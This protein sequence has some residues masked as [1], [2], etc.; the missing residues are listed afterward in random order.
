MPTITVLLDR[1]VDAN[2]VI[3]FE[4]VGRGFMS[5]EGQ[6][7]K[8]VVILLSEA[9]WKSAFAA[10]PDV[11]GKTISLNN[12]FYAIA[13][14]IPIDRQ[15][16]LDSRTQAW[17]PLVD[18]PGGDKYSNSTVIDV[19][20]RLRPGITMEQAQRETAAA[21]QRLGLSKGDTGWLHRLNAPLGGETWTALFSLMA[22]VCFL[23]LIACANIANLLLERTTTRQRETAIR[24]AIGA[25][26]FRLMKQFLV[27]SLVLSA[28]GTLAALILVWWGLRL[29]PK[30]LIPNL[31]FIT[32][33]ETQLNGRVLLFTVAATILTTLLC[34]VIPAIRA[35]G[36]GVIN[37]LKG[38]DRSLAVTPIGKRLQY[39]LQIPQVALTL[40]LLCGTALL[41]NSFSRLMWSNPGYDTGGL[42]SIDFSISAQDQYS[43]SRQAFIFDQ[44]RMQ[45][46]SVPGVRSVALGRS[47]PPKTAV[48]T[49]RF[50]AEGSTV[51]PDLSLD[52]HKSVIDSDTIPAMGLKLIAGRNFSSQDRAGAPRVAII[53]RQTAELMWP[54]QN[55]IGKRFAD[56]DFP[57]LLER[58]QRSISI[59]EIKFSDYEV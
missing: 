39:F 55:A 57:E 52:F 1:F 14:V 33:Y 59:N 26:R 46:Q 28:A 20:A 27:E 16:L 35:S 54:G 22:A 48:F 50:E 47:L 38:R 42:L 7:G 49:S 56:W 32:A 25:T 51:S 12:R 9:L 29:I 58:R 23:L 3:R 13:G 2:G 41:V 45:L 34:G 11:V 18:R 36:R 44:L 37:G 40:I 53:D 8:D 5:E 6:P 10:D 24:T 21:Y 17:L 31:G 43:R 19:I 30:N 4:R 15:Y